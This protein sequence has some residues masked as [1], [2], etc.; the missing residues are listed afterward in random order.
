MGEDGPVVWVVEVVVEDEGHVLEL[1]V[2]RV[3]IAVP[4]VKL[5]VLVADERK[6]EVEDLCACRRGEGE[7]L[8]KSV[9]M[10]GGGRHVQ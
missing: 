5:A 3:L 10:G 1:A 8:R 9:L 6:D 7:A 4:G 2:P